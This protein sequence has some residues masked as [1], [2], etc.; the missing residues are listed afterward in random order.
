MT[1]EDKAT[2]QA[3]CEPVWANYT[4][5]IEDLLQKMIEVQK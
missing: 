2:A 1:A 3:A 4:E 5:G